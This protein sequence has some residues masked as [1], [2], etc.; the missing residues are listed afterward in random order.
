MC[1]T[2]LIKTRAPVVIHTVE[3]NAT[4][5]AVALQ[6][7]KK[8]RDAAFGDV[9]ERHAYVNYAHGDESVE[10]LYGYVLPY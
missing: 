2:D 8:M 5:D 4:L 7:G 3:G 6:W 10:E 9:H 1:S